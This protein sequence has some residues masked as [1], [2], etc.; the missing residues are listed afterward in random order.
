[1]RCGQR[2]SPLMIASMPNRLRTILTYPQNAVACAGVSAPCAITFRVSSSRAGPK[3]CRASESMC[4][5]RG[6]EKGSSVFGGLDQRWSG[7]SVRW[8]TTH[9]WMSLFAAHT[10][11]SVGEA[12]RWTWARRLTRAEAIGRASALSVARLPAPITIEPFGSS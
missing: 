1:M 4:Q 5:E 3:E 7:R 12:S 9:G 10:S 8:S 6:V 11:Q 2:A